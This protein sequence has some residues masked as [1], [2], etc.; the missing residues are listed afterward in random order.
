M[1]RRIAVFFSLVILLAAAL[2]LSVK[3]Q[4]PEP[5]LP[6]GFY[7]FEDELPEGASGHIPEGMRSED[8]SEVA[9]GINEFLS[10]E[11]ILEVIGDE[12][13]VG[14]SAGARLF[15]TLGVMISL[16][17]VI[18]ALE[19]SLSSSALSGALRICRVGVVFCSVFGIISSHLGEVA[20]FFERLNSLMLSMIPVLASVLAMGGN[21]AGAGAGRGAL[22]TFVAVSENVLAT[23]VM[24]VCLI[25]ASATLSSGL[26]PELKLSRVTS[27]VKK[28][29]N[30]G[31]GLIMTVLLTLLSANSSIASSADGVTARAAKLVSSTVIPVVG[32]SVGDTLRTVAASA[33]Y[34]KSVVGIGGIIFLILL[35]L[36]TL[37]S[38]LVTRLIF[39]VMSAFSEMLG[40]DTE[41]GFISELG[42]IYAC[43]I[44]VVSM[45]SVMFI[46][47]L[48]IFVRVTVAAA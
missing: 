5:E 44:A 42:N 26:V 32:G 36:P 14:L 9:A 39:I 25:L 38:L 29:Y 47:A 40:C 48:Y 7:S 34:I 41:A 17:A 22:Y 6:E 4:E 33:G 16:S 45:T 37:I 15:V 21:V 27:A 12:L 18:A 1:A 35:L 30:F 20:G 8:L 23:S 43:L 10:L 46:I 24:P 28:I 11:N 13:S 19:N 3:A 31:L 2:A